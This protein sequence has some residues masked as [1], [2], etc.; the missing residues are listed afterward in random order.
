MGLAVSS[1]QPQMVAALL[2]AGVGVAAPTAA[3]ASP[4]Q[5]ACSQRMPSAHLISLLL[6]HG[7]QPNAPDGRGLRPLQLLPQLGESAS[8]S[9]AQPQMAQLTAV[10]EAAEAL[11]LGGARFDAKDASGASLA[12]GPFHPSVRLIATQS[13][14][15]RKGDRSVPKLEPCSSAL[16]RMLTAQLGS[17]WV[18]DTAAPQCMACARRFTDYHRRHHCRVLGVVVCDDCSSRRAHLGEHKPAGTAAPSSSAVR[19]CDAAFN[20]VRQLQATAEEERVAHAKQR[21]EA[22]VHAAFVAQEEAEKRAQLLGD[23]RA[24]GT[25][26]PAGQPGGGHDA[27]HGAKQQAA[28]TGAASAA[29]EAM[30]ALHER[31]EKLGVLNDRVAELG[32]EAEDFLSSARKLRE[33]AER[34]SRWF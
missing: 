8:P 31:G 18:D 7:A 2:D 5:L 33:Q 22:R 26:R 19:V 3:G 20:I 14:T 23:G 30:D 11:V 12:D 25:S 32:R 10:C 1:G 13:A 16:Y 27:R 9:G 29:H 17:V 34:S 28:A 4:L 21:E 6:A 15:R 24:A